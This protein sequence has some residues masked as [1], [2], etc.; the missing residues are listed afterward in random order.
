MKKI[1][2]HEIK[3]YILRAKSGE[4]KLWRRRIIALMLIQTFFVLDFAW[5]GGNDLLNLNTSRQA[6]TLSPTIQLNN[7]QLKNIFRRIYRREQRLT[8]LRE[9][10]T[11]AVQM[12]ALAA[13]QKTIERKAAESDQKSKS[14]K[15]KFNLK[16]KLRQMKRFF[17]YFFL[18][19]ISRFVVAGIVGVIGVFIGMGVYYY[20]KGADLKGILLRASGMIVVFLVYCGYEI[21]MGYKKKNRRVTDKDIVIVN[22]LIEAERR[23]SGIE[24]DSTF[25]V[26]N[27]KLILKQNGAYYLRQGPVLLAHGISLFG[28]F[29][30]GEDIR[31]ERYVE[32]LRDT[33]NITKLT[34]ISCNPEGVR[35]K[36][37]FVEGVDVV[38]PSS[39]SDMGTLP[40]MAVYLSSMY[41]GGVFGVHQVVNEVVPVADTSG[42]NGGRWISSAGKQIGNSISPVIAG[43]PQISATKEGIMSIFEDLLQDGK[44]EWFYGTLVYSLVGINP[45][46]YDLNQWFEIEGEKTGL[47][48]KGIGQY[49]PAGFI[50]EE[51]RNDLLADDNVSRIKSIYFSSGLTLMNMEH[52]AFKDSIEDKK[53]QIYTFAQK[54]FFS[55]LARKESYV[56][57]LCKSMGFGITEQELL[58]VSDILG[59]MAV[60]M[61]LDKGKLNTDFP[62]YKNQYGGVRKVRRYLKKMFVAM[63]HS[64]HMKLIPGIS[65][66]IAERCVVNLSAL[67]LNFMTLVE[68]A[69]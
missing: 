7:L 1:K 41:V 48:L 61:Y 64:S 65:K 16:K 18:Q 51:L 21:W 46:A 34:V 14:R 68:Q 22:S 27:A 55:M 28:T 13:I 57:S 36:P 43:I 52:P 3:Y 50:D 31:I 24:R 56:Q 25:F 60:D 20:D 69:I 8:R 63:S 32:Y 9:K 40:G 30:T 11:L 33:Y 15:K 26:P 59:R 67:K 17:K 29:Y 45:A 6:G 23:H 58:Q 12:A 4:A 42:N 49:M 5:C 54:Y 47:I 62:E 2:I 35:L 37:M 10:R 44:P 66:I 53:T 19:N 39:L 38:Y